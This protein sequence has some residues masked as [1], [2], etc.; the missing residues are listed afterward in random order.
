MTLEYGG[1]VILMVGPKEIEELY[2]E[3]AELV[4]LAE[5]NDVKCV[6]VF[7][8]TTKLNKALAQPQTEESC[9]NGDYVE[10]GRMW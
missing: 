3:L 4:N 6:K 7:E 2:D 9:M 5:G 8:L 1:Q 10:T